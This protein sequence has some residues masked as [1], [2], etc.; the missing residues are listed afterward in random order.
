MAT[1]DFYKL[2]EEMR[3][4]QAKFFRTKDANVLMESKELERQVD[5]AIREHKESQ[6]GKLF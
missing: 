4:A 2:V 6:Q 5:R 3:T 1:E